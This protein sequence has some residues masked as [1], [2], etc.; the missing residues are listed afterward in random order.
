MFN[1]GLWGKVLKY[2]F[3]KDRAGERLDHI[4]KKIGKSLLN[5]G[6]GMIRTFPTSMNWISWKIGIGD[7]LRISIDPWIGYIGKHLLFDSPIGD[8]HA[9]GITRLVYTSNQNDHV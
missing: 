5:F 8:L 1:E 9:K 3:L 6:K 4:R 7:K 2:K